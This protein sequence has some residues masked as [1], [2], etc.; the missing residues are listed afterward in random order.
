VVAI[1]GAKSE[2]QV[3]QNAE[4]VNVKLEDR[5]LRLIEEALRF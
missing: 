4:A 3:K 2:D 5:D 1:P